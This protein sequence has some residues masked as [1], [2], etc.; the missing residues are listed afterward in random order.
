MKQLTALMMVSLL[1]FA[2]CQKEIDVTNGK[3]I[4]YAESDFV[5][6]EVIDHSANKNGA[7][8]S[9]MK[10]VIRQVNNA[11]N[12]YRLVLKVDSVSADIDGDRV[13]E[14]VALGDN[15]IVQASLSVPNPLNP[16]DALLVF[17]QTSLT[18]RKQNENGYYVFVSDQFVTDV[19]FDYELVQLNYLIAR[20]KFD[21]D[22]SQ[23]PS[24]QKIA[25]DGQYFILPNGKSVEQDPKVAKFRKKDPGAV[26]FF[27]TFDMVSYDDPLGQVTQVVFKG[28]VFGLNNTKKE[29]EVPLEAILVETESSRSIGVAAWTLRDCINFYDENTKSWKCGNDIGSVFTDLRDFR[30]AVYLLNEAGAVLKVN[31]VPFYTVTVE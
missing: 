29:K 20:W 5:D 13:E 24:Y 26:K 2:S 25:G 15:A 21:D 18:F 23:D 16:D 14:M 6:N 22:A 19:D 3:D 8:R 12:T 4:S 7:R 11:E 9:N 10:V 30:G 1:I 28:V 17:S 27:E 31:N